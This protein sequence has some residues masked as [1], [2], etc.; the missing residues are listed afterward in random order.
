MP[1]IAAKQSIV[2]AAIRDKRKRF[3]LASRP[4]G[5]SLAGLWEFPGGKVEQDE[6][7]KAA[8]IRE[9][10]EELDIT[11][12]QD[13]FLF[14]TRLITRRLIFTLF[15]YPQFQGSITPQEQ[16][17]FTWVTP[18]SFPLHKMPPPNKHL[19]PSLLQWISNYDE[20]N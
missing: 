16:Q 4:E 8:L 13:L 11:I 7:L 15:F 18:D 12:Q 1:T 2:I 19:I 20:A 9:L 10:K 5:K 14:V 6:K 17:E 3:L